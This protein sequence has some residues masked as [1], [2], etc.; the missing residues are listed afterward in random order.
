MGSST[1]R[2]PSAR[3]GLA[4]RLWRE[5]IRPQAKTL[6]LTLLFMVLLAA[7]SAAYA[8][9]AKLIIDRAGDLTDTDAV[10][11]ARSFALY[12][13]PVLLAVTLVSGLSMYA[14]RVLSNTLALNAVAGLQK[15][16]FGAVHSGSHSAMLAEPTGTLVSRFVSDVGVVS[17]ALIRVVTNLGKDVLTVAFLLATMLWLDWQLTLLVIVVYPLALYPVI[18]IS[19]RLRGR[20]TDVQEQ[21]GAITS[22]LT[23]S[24]RAARTVKT[25]RLEAHEAAR[26]GRSFDE[27][28][29][30]M[31]RLVG[32]QARV[33]PIL[34]VVGG[35][36]VAGLFTFGVFQVARGSSTPGDIAGVLVAL[37]SAAPRVR[38]LGTLGT[39]YQEGLASLSRIYALIDRAPETDRPGAVELSDVEGRIEFSNVTFR[40]SDGTTALEDVT[41]SVAPGETLALVGPS[42]GG[43]ST[44]LDLIPRLHDPSEG[45]IRID[46][47]DIRDATLASLRSHIALVSQHVTVFESTV[48]AN[49]ALGRPG[50]TPAEIEAAARAADAHGFISEL[51]DG[52]STVLSE[53][54]GSLSGGQRQRIAIARA[55]LR[56]APILLLDEATSALDTDTQSS[57]TAALH[58]LRK[59]RTTLMVTHRPEAAE[60]A[61]RVV[62]V[63]A[64][65]VLPV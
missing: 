8:V 41:L 22:E 31:L 14:Q 57:V 63:E 65:K 32:D 58:T 36:A 61:D 25:Y 4:G 1:P 62:R 33:D 12:A 7:A 19:K 64:G 16:M 49:I 48:A 27:R 10:E 20:A 39:V 28:I 42:G 9:L 13:V 34:E 40:Y 45:T 52:Y 3:E 37:I 59:G 54:G 30:R 60:G 15:R 23:E 5:E 2:T 53:D 47:T 50:A 26:L 43:K 17:T 46:G 38:A 51:A 24:F 11:A 55:V 21:V 6:A 18:A 35:L 44:L 56:D 29:S